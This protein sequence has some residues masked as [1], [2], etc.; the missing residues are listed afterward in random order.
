MSRLHP[1]DRYLRSVCIDG[2]D[3]ILDVSDAGGALALTLHGADTRTILPLCQRARAMFDLDAS[4]DEIARVLGR[5]RFL[6]PLLKE[7]AGIRV[8]GAWDGFEL[9]V[10]AILGQQVSVA[11]ATTLAGRVAARYG[12]PIDV[13]VPDADQ[14]PTRRFPTAA[15]LARV[16]FNNMGIV[17]AR[18]DTIRRIARGVVD[19][20]ISF[21][22]SQDSET[23][24]RSL[25]AIKGI[26]E[27]TAQYVAMRVLKDPDAFLHSDLGL[28][29]AFDEPGKERIKPAELRR[30][31]EAWR[32]WRAY[33]AVLLWEADGNSGG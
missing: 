28:L 4:P 26:G 20:S 11:A 25:V 8:P 6:K 30:R 15:K 24:C 29:R 14:V 19:G 21:D 5:D 7:Q 3:C 16:R 17:T 31:S 22:P 23:F 12:E 9:M 13:A 10:R 1:R 27:W 33:A 32:P 2:N 18:I